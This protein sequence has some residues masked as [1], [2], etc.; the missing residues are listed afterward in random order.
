MAAS[1]SVG[2]DRRVNP[3]DELTI[4]LTLKDRPAFTYRWMAYAESV[5]MPFRV[6]IADGGTDD[7][8]ERALSGG[9]AFPHVSYEYQRCPPDRTYR[10]FYAKVEQALARIQTPLVVMADNDD[11]FVVDGLREAARFL[12]GHADHV[13]CGGRSAAFWIDPGGAADGTDALYGRSAWKTTFDEPP[14]AD[15]TARDRL[16]SPVL[17]GHAVYYHVRRTAMLRAQFQ[18]LRDWNVENLFLHEL[19]I[20]FLT[21]IA[22]RSRV[23]EGPY[24]ARQWNAPG[25]SART[26]LQAHG[27]WIGCMLHPTWS[28]EFD[29][30]LSVTAAALAARDGI[31][32]DEARRFVIDCYRREMA[33]SILSDVLRDPAVT[34]PMAVVAGIVRR[35]L[36]LPPVHPARRLARAVYRGTRSIPVD[37]VRGTA[38][39]SRPVPHARADA[40]PIDDFLRRRTP[41]PDPRW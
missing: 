41:A 2:R 18:M 26:H 13:T 23:L 35:L 24:I 19:V 21:A 5:R 6:L 29:R 1:R 28:A 40:A 3:F 33:P 17:W 12:S 31:P 14:G 11:F 34:V 36:A 8:V 16:R 39:W 20:G 37:V 10:D 7:G 9:A 15:T 25:S 30:F 22:G 27:D 4:L 32:A 38:L